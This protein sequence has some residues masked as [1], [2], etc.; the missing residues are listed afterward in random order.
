MPDNTSLLKN[1][2]N[3]VKGPSS[4]QQ[5]DEQIK[6]QSGTTTTS[7]RSSTSSRSYTPSSKTS[8]SNGALLERQIS[9][10][11]DTTSSQRLSEE[12]N[13]QETR[14]TGTTQR[15]PYI[16]PQPEPT[17]TE[18]L[19]SP[20]SPTKAKTDNIILLAR[21]QNR[22]IR[23]IDPSGQYQLDS[24]KIVSGKQ[25]Q[26]MITRGTI[27]DARNVAR[28]PNTGSYIQKE[29]QYYHLTPE[30][31][32]LYR[33]AEPTQQ[34][35]IYDALRPQPERPSGFV[36]PIYNPMTGASTRAYSSLTGSEKTQYGYL[37]QPFRNEP[38][39][40]WKYH[41]GGTEYLL[42]LNDQKRNQLIDR[43]LNGSSGMFPKSGIGGISAIELSRRAGQYADKYYYQSDAAKLFKDAT[44]HVTWEA[45]T[46][47]PTGFKETTFMSYPLWQRVQITGM[48]TSGDILYGTASLPQAGYRLL[49]GK[50]VGPDIMKGWEEVRTGSPY[51]IVTTGISEGAAYLTG[52]ESRAWERFKRDPISGLVGTGSAAFM[53][54]GIGKGFH[55]AKVGTI[56]G[57][58]KVRG[59]AYTKWGLNLP[60]YAQ[61]SYYYPQRILRRAWVKTGTRNIDDIMGVPY[62]STETLQ[63]GGLSYAPG[64]TPMERV[65][66]TIQRSLE[67]RGLPLSGDDFLIGSSSGQRIGGRYIIQSKTLHELPS[68][69]GTPYG[70]TPT[71]FYR[72]GSTG[73]YSSSTTLFPKLHLPSGFAIRTKDIFKPPFFNT[74]DDIVRYAGQQP[75]GS[76]GM[77]GPKMYLGGPET[78]INIFG[79][80]VLK[81]FL[82]EQGTFMQRLRGYQFYTDVPLGEVGYL[83]GKPLI[84]AVPVVF[85]SPVHKGFPVGVSS[86]LN[87]VKEDIRTIATPTSSMGSS[88]S[89]FNPI[90]VAGMFTDLNSTS[91]TS[92]GSSSLGRAYSSYNPFSMS[93]GLS[94][95]KVSS[96]LSSMSRGF[97]SIRSSLSKSRSSPSSSQGISSSLSKLSS[98]TLTSIGSLSSGLSKMRSRPSRGYSSNFFT[99]S[100][101]SSSTSSSISFPLSTSYPISKPSI[102]SFLGRMPKK[103]IGKKRKEIGYR[104]R[105]FDVMKIEKLFSM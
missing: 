7:T 84:E 103:R 83:S 8:S 2:I 35:G 87:R 63:P 18:R 88:T 102:E 72:F 51:D 69:S 37:F 21:N 92:F 45:L 44:R 74:Y 97:K 93:S 9:V 19:I 91:K 26:Y 80:T 20:V 28:M 78:E 56:E 15:T 54:W 99:S 23:D 1:I 22:Q 65:N 58:G 43:I 49:T 6:K 14:Q 53:M 60:S 33:Y 105:Q 46:S 71:R 50:Q 55:T 81:R 96:P 90:S 89:I 34:R 17:A 16:A 94:Y 70:Y 5:L 52:G 47:T 100:P 61:I 101:V 4:S 75:K 57:L 27:Q 79:K 77:I 73:G 66:W 32:Y 98:S 36:G 29:G 24:G 39:E 85:T 62:H 11:K 38:V 48:Q 41:P 10:V 31:T 13:K 42:S 86:I 59:Y 95:T 64:R 25:L 68:L 104:F 67:S 30:I 3:V 76:W 40:T 82:P 12:L